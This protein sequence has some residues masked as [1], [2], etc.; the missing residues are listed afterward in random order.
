MEEEKPSATL[1]MTLTMYLLIFGDLYFVEF[2][3]CGSDSGRAIYRTAEN[4]SVFTDTRIHAKPYCFP[5]GYEA[6]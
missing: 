1:S 5:T 3:S 6:V 2:R 4:R